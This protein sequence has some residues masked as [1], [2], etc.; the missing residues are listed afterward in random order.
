MLLSSTLTVVDIIDVTTV[1]DAIWLGSIYSSQ[2]DWKWD[3][4]LS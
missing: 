1:F 4:P 2:E 3:L